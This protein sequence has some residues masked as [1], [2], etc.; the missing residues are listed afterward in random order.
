M[1]AA[2]KY[3][4]LLRSRT[5]RISEIHITLFQ[6]PVVFTRTLYEAF[7]PFRGSAW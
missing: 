2:I 6:T 4:Q 1:Y 7:G 5:D 3:D